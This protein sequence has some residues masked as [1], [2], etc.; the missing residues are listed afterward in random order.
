MYQPVHFGLIAGDIC[1]PDPNLID[2]DEPQDWYPFTSHAQFELTDFLYRHVQMSAGNIDTL[3][4]LWE[5]YLVA[6]H[7]HS[8]Y[9]HCKEMYQRIDAI[10]YGKVDWHSFTLTYNYEDGT[11]DLPSWMEDPQVV[12]Y[13]D[14]LKVLR[15]II[16][17]PSFD[18]EFDYVPYHEY[19]DG[20][21]HFQ[22]FMS[23]DWAWKQAVSDFHI[24]LYNIV[25]IF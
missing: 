16:A 12:W 25:P 7:G 6:D 5:S 18:G 15:S 9:I 4:E 22:N 10:P 3:M 13:R 20:V 14:P 17:N 8:P 2:E 1:D 21:H 11:D 23:G 19:I 24:I